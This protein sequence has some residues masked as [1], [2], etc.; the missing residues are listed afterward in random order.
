MAQ[1]V[2]V[3][4]GREHNDARLQ[5][6]LVSSLAS[7]AGRI[8]GYQSSA[9]PT[10]FSP[11]S[12]DRVRCGNSLKRASCSIVAGVVSATL[13]LVVLVG[14]YMH[15][16][17]LVRVTLAAGLLMVFFLAVKV[18][19]TQRARL[20]ARKVEWANRELEANH[21]AQT[22]EEELK[23]LNETLAQRVLF[24]RP[25][26]TPCSGGSGLKG[27]V[28]STRL[29]TTRL[30]SRRRPNRGSSIPSLRQRRLARGLAWG[31]RLRTVSSQTMGKRWYEPVEGGG[32]RFLVSLPIAPV[33]A[34]EAVGGS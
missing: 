31:Y 21:C 27:I 13:V 3:N 22:V 29:R 25:A 8:A 17:I 15:S 24:Q 10:V 28:W 2:V 33:K 19:L 5:A 1:T 4:V 34:T 7:L 11:G 23:E 32:V 16:M 30:A 14:W 18:D 26:E 12:A 20:N 9:T 6:L